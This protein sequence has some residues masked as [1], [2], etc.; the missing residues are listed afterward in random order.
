MHHKESREG[1]EMDREKSK[2]R[3]A[4]IEHKEKRNKR[5]GKAHIEEQ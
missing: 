5:K 2:K 1:T 3:S 4:E